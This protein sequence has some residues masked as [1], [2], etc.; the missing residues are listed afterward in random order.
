MGTPTTNV[1]LAK[2]ISSALASHSCPARTA[3]RRSTLRAFLMPSDSS[4]RGRKATTAA[5]RPNA[6]ALASRATSPPI[7]ETTAVAASAV[8]RPGSTGKLSRTPAWVRF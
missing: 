2:V 8:G 4:S 3:Q 6:A 5:S 7:I 1:G